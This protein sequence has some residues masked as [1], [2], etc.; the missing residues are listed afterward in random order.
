MKKFLTIVICMMMEI[1]SFALAPESVINP[2]NEEIGERF[3][4]VFAVTFAMREIKFLM[5]QKGL[6]REGQ[7]AKLNKKLEDADISVVLNMVHNKFNSTGRGYKEVLLYLKNE[8]K[9]LK[10]VLPE[11]GGRLT[12]GEINDA[13]L[14]GTGVQYYDHPGIEN[15]AY[16]FVYVPEQFLDEPRSEAEYEGIKKSQNIISSLAKETRVSFIVPMFKEERRLNP[17]SAANPLGEDAFRKKVAQF[18]DLGRYNPL[19][20]WQM[21]FIDDG[22]PGNTNAILVERMWQE[23]RVKYAAAGIYLPEDA[24]LI[25]RISNQKKNEK[26]SKKGW[27]VY[28]GMLK[29]LH[30]GWAEYIGYTDTDISVDM[31]LTGLLVEPLASGESDVAIGSRKT[32]GGQAE[33]IPFASNMASEMYSTLVHNVLPPIKDIKDTQRGFKLFS[34]NTVRAIWKK[35]KDNSFTFDTELLL[36]SKRQKFNIKEIPIAWFDSHD[37]TT[38]NRMKNM[39]W[40]VMALLEQ[41]KH[42]SNPEDNFERV[43]EIAEI[44]HEENMK[45]E[46]VPLLPQKTILCHIISDTIIPHQSYILGQLEQG[47][48]E[49][50]FKEK[51]IC[52]KVKTNRTFAEQVKN[53][54]AE[55]TEYYKS[56]YGAD[57]KNYTIK[58]DIACPDKEKAAEVREKLG[59]NALAFTA[60]EKNGVVQ[61]ES[62]I[63]ALRALGTGDI[64]KLIRVYKFLTGETPQLITEDINKLAAA[65]IFILPTAEMQIIEDLKLNGIIKKKIISAA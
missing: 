5:E 19:F 26:G 16:S 39:V 62:I 15:M 17:Q 48:R 35:T 28:Q 8:K 43:M 7:I 25:E 3:K 37:A 22:T 64:E 23:A 41:R 47:M 52:L 40:S 55:I 24:V 51:V 65:L 57:F 4:N 36:L 18:I 49:E 46:Y 20:R 60:D 10:L 31:R 27:A 44:I 9:T 32:E 63:L 54:M 38:F 6:P 11:D 61:V 2:M 1:S 21:I 59:L 58:F 14:D 33:K 53:R 45:T 12:E 29:A 50:S 30:D 42:I 56:E 13:G 34:K